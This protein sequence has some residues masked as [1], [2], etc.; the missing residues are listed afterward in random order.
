MHAIIA[1]LIAVVAWLLFLWF[2]IWKNFKPCARDLYRSWH[3]S[4]S[5]KKYL[6]PG[7]EP[8]VV[9]VDIMEAVARIAPCKLD[10]FFLN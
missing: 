6:S 4:V 9:V 8:N 2:N 1:T 5:E 7:F 3:V 10:I